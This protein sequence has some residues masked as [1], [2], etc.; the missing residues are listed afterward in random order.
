MEEG[1]GKETILSLKKV[2]GGS[3]TSTLLVAEDGGGFWTEERSGFLGRSR[4]SYLR[5]GFS[6][7]KGKNPPF[8]SFLHFRSCTKIDQA[9]GTEEKK[10]IFLRFFLSFLRDK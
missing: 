10:D 6:L 1:N 5:N 8:H 2:F 7:S 3:L 4:Q 9:D